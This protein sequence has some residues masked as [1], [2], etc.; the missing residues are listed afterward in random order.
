[1]KDNIKTDRL[2]FKVGTFEWINFFGL[3]LG[4]II[5]SLMMLFFFIK[6]RFSFES[7]GNLI[8]FGALITLGVATYFFQL[9]KLKFKTFELKGDIEDF[10]K[11]VREI[12]INNNW[13][14]EY[15]NNSFLQAVCRASVFNLDLI[16]LKF[17]KGLVKWNVIHH[18]ESRNSIA[19]LLS[20][21]RYGRRIIRQ[22]IACA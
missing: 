1:M 20:L 10:K 18:P 16:T 4:L 3:P 9:R 7:I 2:S 8:A 22:I 5:L 17:H 6:D 19:A 12:L 14:I 13:G 11:N 21:N 15:D